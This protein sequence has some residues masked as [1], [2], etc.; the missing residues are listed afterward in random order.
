[1]GNRGDDLISPEVQR[2]TIDVLAK[3]EGIRIVAEIQDIDKSGRYFAKRRV[4]EV[5]EGV[6]D[7]SWRYVILW[8]WSRWGRNLKESQIHLAAVEEVGGVVRAAT[9]DVDPSTTIGRFTRDQLLSIAQLQSDMISDSWK[10][11]QAK[12]RRDGLP[13]SGKPRWGYVYEGKRYRVDESLRETLKAAYESYVSGATLRGMALEWNA[14]GL[15]TS[16]GALWN[17]TRLARMLDTGF[18]AGLIRER[19]SQDRG[20]YKLADFDVWRV[21]V[22]EAIISRELFE[23]YRERRLAQA[24]LAPRVR[25]GAY[26]LSGLMACGYPGCGGAMGVTKSGRVRAT[27]WTCNRAALAKA[28][29]PNNVSD[30]RATGLILDWI[31]RHVQLGESVTEEARRLEAGRQ[32]KNDVEA[33]D[34]E[35]GRLLRKRARLSDSWTDE[36]IEREDYLRQRVE[37]ADALAAAQA[38]RRL[39]EE[40]VAASGITYV[41][42]FGALLDEWDRFTPHD[43]REALA[44]VFK[45]IVVHPGPFGPEKVVPVPIWQAD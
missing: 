31:E 21:G 2:H 40:R 35:I 14:A 11:A 19:T 1:M 13:A 6:K 39:A 29:A 32:A 3:R 4:Q 20:K 24:A 44:A 26:A 25:T 33:L 22:H 5:I 28:H 45:R 38:G 18:A 10:D 23:Q 42:Q 9:E 17:G 43:K 27:S 12:R 30:K 34:V 36:M 37:I 8:K 41:R 7:G 15:R 16:T